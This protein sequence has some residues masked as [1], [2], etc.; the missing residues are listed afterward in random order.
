MKKLAQIKRK[1]LMQRIL[2]PAFAAVL[3]CCLIAG[4]IFG[5]G[6]KEEKMTAS[7]DSSV[8]SFTPGASIGKDI[9]TAGMI[10]FRLNVS[11]MSQIRAI[12]I[13]VSPFKSCSLLF[14]EFNYLYTSN[15]GTAGINLDA[16]T[17][18]NGQTYFDI[19]LS[20]NPQIEYQVVADI[21]K[22]NNT[23]DRIVSA[24]R[25]V[26]SVLEKMK[27]AGAPDYEQAEATYKT[28]MD[29][30]IDSKP[31]EKS[32]RIIA[33]STT[34]QPDGMVKASISLSSDVVDELK[35]KKT[36]A[37]EKTEIDAST[38]SKISKF[39]SDRGIST[40]SIGYYSV[41][42]M[43]TEL[44]FYR[45]YFTRKITTHNELWLMSSNDLS[46]YQKTG[47]NGGA[48][49]NLKNSSPV[50]QVSSHGTLLQRFSVNDI[51]IPGN[52][53]VELKIDPS[54]LGS[55][56]K[57]YYV[58]L[59][60]VDESRY[61]LQEYNVKWGSAPNTL[62][63]EVSILTE[64]TENAKSFSSNYLSKDRK[65]W[66]AEIL[67]AANT[68]EMTD[69]ELKGYQLL[70]GL[71]TETAEIPVT[72]KYKALSGGGA[73]ITDATKVFNI[74]S[75][76]A[77]NMNAVTNALFMLGEFKQLSDF[78]V[79]RKNSYFD[80]ND[81]E[82]QTGDRIIR[83][84]TGYK[85]EYDS[86]NQKGTL[87]IEYS[88]FH[89]KDL[90]I[91]MQS[92][93]AESHMTKDFYTANA[94]QAN[95]KITVVF[96]YDDLEMWGKNNCGWL[97]EL[98][99]K[100]FS[101]VDNSGGKV[102]IA[103]NGSARTLTLMC[104]EEDENSLGA[105]SIKAVSEIVE[106]VLYSMTYKYKIIED[107]AG[108]LTE[109][110]KTSAPVKLMYSDLLAMS[111]GNFMTEYG[112]VINGDLLPSTLANTN[113]CTAK[114]YRKAYNT[115]NQT[116]EIT[117]VYEYRPVFKVT[118][119]QDKNFYKFLPL[120]DTTLLYTGEYF[121][122]PEQHDQYDGFRLESISATLETTVAR[123]T[124]GYKR[125]E[126]KLELLRMPSQGKV[127]PVCLNFTDKWLIEINYMN[128][129]KQTPFAEKTKYSGEIR[130]KDYPD[131]Y[132][133]KSSDL[134]AILGL[135]SMSIIRDRSTV[136]EITVS[137]DGIGTYAV[138]TTYT[139][140]SM[141]QRD[142]S[143]KQQNEVCVPLSCY[144]EWCEDY[145][146]DWTI[147][148]LNYAG[149]VYFRYSNEVKSENLYGFFSVAIFDNKV[150]DLNDV[151]SSF[152]STGCKTFH[153]EEE[154]R[155]SRIYKFFRSD[156]GALAT[157]LS[158]ST[159]GLISGK[160]FKCAVV[161]IAL[162]RIALA[163][164]ES[165]LSDSDNAV[166]TSRF[167]FLDGTSDTPIMADN[168]ST[169]PGNTNG[170]AA[171]AAL[172]VIDGVKEFFLSLKDTIFNSTYAKIIAVGFGIVLIVLIF[173]LIIRLIRFAFSGSGGKRRR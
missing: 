31:G 40:S 140:L 162:R 41:D 2:I 79:V 153:S 37:E 116:C 125:D 26:V 76:Y 66:A 33:G 144:K 57:T 160:L 69:E 67:A 20:V 82:R 154:V 173:V 90:M 60:Q 100:N 58:A 107:A 114:D 54:L 4:I 165:P 113:Y 27:A 53:V 150:S 75:L 129:Y 18:K 170:A 159:A 126:M 12:T 138:N 80:K 108:E 119:N 65:T 77:Q 52:R 83:Q 7:A 115:E 121:Y 9:S 1:N 111:Y 34:L 124:P 73:Y 145:G 105:I 5:F 137:Y 8:A 84:A 28:Y 169:D 172:G 139:P 147:L 163:F 149:N 13:Q 106:D 29:S 92:N 122:I 68:A 47:I 55:G 63:K 87:T 104:S 109:K 81:L 91:T 78:N 38:K 46:L 164:C 161:G 133:L 95:G 132:A 86:T 128:Q 88:D 17:Q 71:Y 130:V 96:N 166:Y 48:W 141:V 70:A 72:V 103:N 102:L 59:V 99:E 143:G 120:S 168:G 118:D 74:K 44:P 36:I 156:E 22:T 93:D 131:I 85:Y 3:F 101:I 42:R 50:A 167:F 94:T 148:Y 45:R 110:T 142:S 171:N 43:Q 151:F 10:R 23:V 39:F 15:D 127:L 123:I 62:H 112:S 61:V 14:T 6:K 64:T 89:Y 135:K 25:S 24:V 98:K 155:G 49:T 21:Q 56:S 152:D 97:F 136:D 19:K 117:V 35:K 146:K 30:V 158:F 11:D 51:D 16:F 134:A 157:I 32:F